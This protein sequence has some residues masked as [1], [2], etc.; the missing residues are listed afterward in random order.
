MQVTNCQTKQQHPAFKMK[1]TCKKRYGA[2]DLIRKEIADIY[3]QA[4]PETKKIYF[5]D[6]PLNVSEIYKGF[7]TAFDEMTKGYGKKAQII[8]ASL[9]DNKLNILFTDSKGREYRSNNDFLVTGLLP[10][11]LF[12]KGTPYSSS[13]KMIVADLADTVAKNFGYG[14]KNEMGTLFRKMDK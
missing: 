12:D 2:L 1:I 4:T 6:K 5:G 14:P 10:N 9:N 7:Q 11:S 13:V 8:K 3:K